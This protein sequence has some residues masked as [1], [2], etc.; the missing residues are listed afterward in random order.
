MSAVV[1]IK[2]MR[3]AGGR[4][5]YFVSIKVGDR[6]VTPH[7]FREEYKAAYHVAL[8]D[9]LLNGTGEEPCPVDFGP[10]DWPARKMPEAEEPLPM[11]DHDEIGRKVL[12]EPWEIQKAVV[13]IA[14]HCT[15]IRDEQPTGKV[16]DLAACISTCCLELANALYETSARPRAFLAWAIA[17]FGSIAKLRS[18][19]LN[20]FVEEAIELAHAD[21]ME[22]ST[23]DVLAN[24]VFSRPAG[25]IRKEIGQAQA[26]LEMY[27]ENLDLSSAAMAEIEWKRV[28]RIPVDEWHRRHGEKAAIGIARPIVD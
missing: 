7:V 24:R 10:D 18:E 19:R 8:Y 2:P 23:L 11:A 28:R 16:A 4:T 3:L 9:W 1:S 17:T 22:R 6:E 26:C 27:A 15:A 12:Q 21:G 5:D 25:D 14:A 13:T 20:R